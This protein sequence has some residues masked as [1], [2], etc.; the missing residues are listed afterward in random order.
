MAGATGR[1][2]ARA[3][4]TLRRPSA[5][6]LRD[7]FTIAALAVGLATFCHAVVAEARFIPSL[8]MAPTLD[9]GDRLVIEKVSYHLHSPRRGDIVVFRPPSPAVQGQ[10]GVDP[11]VPW[12]KRVVGLPGDR[13]SFEA[14][15]LYVNGKRVPEP[16]VHAARAGYTLHERSV[17]AGSVFVLGDN[18]GHS[19]DSATWGPL[20]LRNIIGRA[21]FRFWPLSRFGALA[22]P[23]HEVTVARG[24][25]GLW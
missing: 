17:P 13:L 7:A 8:S 9:I 20:P 22:I 11:S 10:W 16:Y 14:G 1:L 3:T 24:V 5:F 2:R 18:R 15:R 21:S 4:G 23:S 12:I 6:G 25:G 19:I